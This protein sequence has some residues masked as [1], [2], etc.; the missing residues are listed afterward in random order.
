MFIVCIDETVK[1]HQEIDFIIIY[2]SKLLEVNEAFDLNE[3][4]S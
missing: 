4:Q 1:Q 2:Q 3:I